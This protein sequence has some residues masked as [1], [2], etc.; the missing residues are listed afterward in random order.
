MA[1]QQKLTACL[2]NNGTEYQILV[3]DVTGTYDVVENP[4]GWEDA[5]TLLANDLVTANL[6]ITLPNGST[7]TIDV[8]SEIDDPVTGIF[9]FDQIGSDENIIITDGLY[10]IKCVLTTS[11]DEYTACV[12]RYFYPNVKCCISKL[13]NSLAEDLT[14]EKLQ[15]DVVKIT[16]WETAL[17]YSANTLDTV[18]ADK[19]LAQLTKFCKHSPC[20][21]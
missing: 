16:S 1:F 20:G 3:K 21:C 11:S 17:Q 18:T 14:N 19:I 12:Q 15:K 9:S 8:L 6:L 4:T 13:V 5:S 2:V 10:T 7:E